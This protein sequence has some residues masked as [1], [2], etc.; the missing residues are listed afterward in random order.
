MEVDDENAEIGILFKSLGLRHFEKMPMEPNIY[1]AYALLFTSLFIGIFF[2]YAAFI[3]KLI[4]DTG[5]FILDFF[6]RD[7]YFCYLIPLMILPTYIVVYINWLAMNFFAN[8]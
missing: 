6:K 2:T 7:Y 3:S 4:P 8:N 1:V 5:I